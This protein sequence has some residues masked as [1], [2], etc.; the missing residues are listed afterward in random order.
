MHKNWDLIKTRIRHDNKVKYYLE[1][2][3]RNSYQKDKI[4]E[5]DIIIPNNNKVSGE[6]KVWK[7]KPYPNEKT[8]N[9]RSPSKNIFPMH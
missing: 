1:P 5:G 8:I 6:K 9:Y 4:G 7:P 2:E 3:R